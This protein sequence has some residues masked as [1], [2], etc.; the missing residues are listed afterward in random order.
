MFLKDSF[1]I[2][3]QKVSSNLFFFQQLNQETEMCNMIYLSKI[4]IKRSQRISQRPRSSQRLY[5]TSYSEQKRLLRKL[6][7]ISRHSVSKKN[8]KA[9][10]TNSSFNHLVFMNTPASL[11]KPNSNQ[12]FRSLYESLIHSILY[13]FCS[14]GGFLQFLFSGVS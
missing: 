2:I 9:Y 5:L 14:S 8:G 11:E 12:L 4:L 13:L 3:K 10:S 6:L 7:L 1:W